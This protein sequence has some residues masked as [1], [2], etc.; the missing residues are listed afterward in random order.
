LRCISNS[1]IGAQDGETITFGSAKTFVVV[2][3]KVEDI[4]KIVER[5]FIRDIF[6]K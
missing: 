2:K 1:S 3:S 5:I 6:F 4:K